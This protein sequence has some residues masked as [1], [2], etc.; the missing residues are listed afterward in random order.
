[1]KRMD[2]RLRGWVLVEYLEGYTN[3][4]SNSIWQNKKGQL[5][6]LFVYG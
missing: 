5:V 1:M 4:V 2:I 3:G 6:R